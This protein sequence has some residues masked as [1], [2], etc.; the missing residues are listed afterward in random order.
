[1]NAESAVSFE[2][3]PPSDEAMGRQLWESVQRLAP[4]QPEFRVRDLWRRRLDP[5]ANARVRA[6]DP[7]GDRSARGAAS[8]L[9]RRLAR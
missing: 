8:D 4:L 7:A 2:F 5:H 1:M 9:R 6:A 3:F